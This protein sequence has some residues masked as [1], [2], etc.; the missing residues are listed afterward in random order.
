MSIGPSTV[1]LNFTE[2]KFEE[3]LPEDL[4]FKEVR[5]GK[6]LRGRL[7]INRLDPKQGTIRIFELNQD[8]CIIGAR[9]I[10]RA[11]NF[12]TVAVRVLP[13]SG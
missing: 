11:V 12:D 6:L 7:G 13:E 2:E 10:N 3:Y 9:N 5:E 1:N 4:V 8:V